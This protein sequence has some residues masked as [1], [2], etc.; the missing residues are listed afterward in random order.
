[1]RILLT[2]TIF[3]FKFFGQ[4]SDSTIYFKYKDKPTLYSV[5]YEKTYYSNG[6]LKFEGWMVQEKPVK[7]PTLFVIN[8]S[9]NILGCAMGVWKRYYKNGSLLAIDSNGIS[10]TSIMKHYIYSKNGCLRQILTAKPLTVPYKISDSKFGGE[11]KHYKWLTRQ[12]Y[13]CS[14][15]LWEEFYI[16]SGQRSGTWRYYKKNTLDWTEEYGKD[17]HRTGTKKYG[18]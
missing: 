9:V 16:N 17:G 4:I 14:E 2:L 1:M 7:K 10:D 5:Q 12:Y 11:I 13:K 3:S 8:D 6:K 18:T 15:I